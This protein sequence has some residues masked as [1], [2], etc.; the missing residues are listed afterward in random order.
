MKISQVAEKYHNPDPLLRL[1]GPANEATISIEGQE[2]KALIDSGAQLSTISESL[3]TAL[4]LPVHKLNTLIEAEVSGGGIIPYVGYVEA[5]LKIPGIKAMNKDSLFMVSNDSPY[6][7][8]VPTQLGTLHIREAILCATD[9][10]INKLATA[11]KT[12]NFPPLEKNLKVT[13]PEFDLNQIKGHVKL[14][15]S[16]TIAP[17]QTILAS[18]LAEC[19]QHFKRVNVLVEPDPDKCYN[20][21]IPIHGYTVL[22]PG[23]SRV[24]VGLQNHSCRKI[25]IAAKSIVAKITAANLV[26]HSLAPNV[27]TEDGQ[28]QDQDQENMNCCS[29]R[30]VPKLT[31]EKEKLIF[32]KIDLSGADS[33]DPKLV[34]EAKQLFRE[35][36]HIFALESLDMGHTSLVK[37]DNR[38]DNYTPFK[39]RYRRIPPH[40]FNEVKNHLKEMIEVGAI[41]KSN[42]PWA[43]AVV[44]VRKKDGSLRFCIDLCKL[45]AHTIKDAYSLPRIDE[46]LDYLGGAMIFTSLDLKSG[47]WQVEMEEGSKPLTAFTI[48]PLGFYECERMPFG[49][50]NA[51]ATF[52]R[53]MEN[54][55]GDLHLNWC[56]IYLDDIIVF[57]NNPEDHLNRLR[58]VFDK[59]E[60]A[61]LKLKPKKCRFFKTK[62]TYVGHIVSAKGI[63]TDP[64]KVEAVKNWT[65]PKTVL[66]VR[67]FQGFTNHYKR[68][69]KGYANVARPLNLL[70]SGGNANRKKMLIEWTEECQI[71]FD[72][73]KDLCTS[74]P[75]L[76]Y[77]NY[78][79]PFQL[80]T[81]ASDLGLG[82]V[83]YQKDENDHQRVIAFASRSLSNTERNYPAYKLEFLALKWAITDQFYEYLYGGQFDVYTDNNP[84]TY[85]L[86]SAKLDATGQRWVASLANYDFRIFYKSGKQMLRQMLSVEYLVTV[87]Q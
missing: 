76:A 13:K 41:C 48:G 29:T 32:D 12:A 55:L 9:T 59:L 51:P 83:L 5:R 65:V 31:P 3:V 74:T 7:E 66:D 71:V 6:M 16:V 34:E 25:T 60:K 72:K 84:L 28:H 33:W 69:I 64:K 43:R 50:T 10:E 79:K 80:Q 21:V 70:V 22:K 52:Q 73:L 36:A 54:C 30:E 19:N 63:E 75:I 24:S 49:L 26:P 4:K 53:L 8:R 15:K 11:W 61:G 20:S 37:Y 81:D 23:S 82:A 42:S 77:A 18:G 86:T 62:I 40:L 45:N 87:T 78:H 47:Y 67:S 2:F 35:Y 14:T 27:E 1:I 38:L 57:S 39:E 56:I 17:F 44:L 46:T 85:V 58:G 68:F